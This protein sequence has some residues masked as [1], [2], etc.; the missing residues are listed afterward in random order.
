[1]R[2]KG[3]V[4]SRKGRAMRAVCV[5]MTAHPE[6]TGPLGEFGTYPGHGFDHSPVWA[7]KLRNVYRLGIQF[8]LV[9]LI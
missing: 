4:W 2:T 8:R 5:R 7:A 6:I 3:R 9:I 1:M